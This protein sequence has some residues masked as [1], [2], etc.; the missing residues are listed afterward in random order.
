MI[1]PFRALEEVFQEMLRDRFYI[2]SQMSAMLVGQYVKRLGLDD[3]LLEVIFDNFRLLDLPKETRFLNLFIILVLIEKYGPAHVL[4]RKFFNK[5]E[6]VCYD[7]LREIFKDLKF[8]LPASLFP[9]AI[10]NTES[11]HSH[12]WPKETA[13]SKAWL[14]LGEINKV[15]EE[16]NTKLEDNKDVSSAKLSGKKKRKKLPGGI[17]QKNAAAL[18]KVSLR[19]VQNWE[20]GQRCPRGYPGLNNPMAFAA[21]ANQFLREKDLTT[22]ALEMNRAIS[23]DPKIIEALHSDSAFSDTSG[24]GDTRGLEELIEEQEKEKAQDKKR[25]GR[26]A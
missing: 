26:R 14:S 11:F 10:D 23:V 24:C 6:S 25:R 18:C 2:N 5:N 19:T 17:T 13:P 21:W 15:I 20:A 16:L 9:G 22:K 1:K 3:E 4:N 12:I 7:K 8:P